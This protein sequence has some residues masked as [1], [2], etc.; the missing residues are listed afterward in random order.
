MDSPAPPPTN[1]WFIL[2]DDFIAHLRIEKGLSNNTS[3]AYATDLNFF[4]SYVTDI[5][6]YEPAGLTTTAILSW[7]VHQKT[8]GMHA[9][10]ISRRLSSLRSFFN[11]L[12]MERIVTVN[13]VTTIQNPK[14]G[15]Y[16][17]DVLSV[18][19]MERLLNAPDIRTHL[20]MRD[21]AILEITYA[22]GLRASEAVTLK[23]HQIDMDLAY[24]RVIGKGNKER[25]T[26]I[27]E[28]AMEILHDYLRKI[29]PLLL[30]TAAS[31]F[32]F[33][34][35]NGR[36]IT[37]QRFWQILKTYAIQAGLKAE[38]SPHSLRHSFATHLLEGGA[39]LRVV[40]MLLGHSSITTTQIYT[41]LD[42]QH[43]RAVH[44]KFHPR[45]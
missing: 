10:T 41:H 30:K 21:R 45:A 17:P 24:L 14:T 27:G 22:C 20:G 2:I 3:E 9:R 11:F 40:Q 38:I 37:R 15:L 25:V 34:G 31:D 36:P 19:E 32:L 16:L 18:E 26:P 6:I 43:L 29:R 33:P 39:D 42:L 13:P 5:G 35:R 23:L 44:K 4:V 1:L 8:Q 7:L 12:R 28:V